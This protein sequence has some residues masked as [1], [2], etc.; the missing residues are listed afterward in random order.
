MKFYI[1]NFEISKKSKTFVVAK[2]SAN[3][4][5]DFNNVYN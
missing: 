5:N 2:I 3:H 4:N 1:Y